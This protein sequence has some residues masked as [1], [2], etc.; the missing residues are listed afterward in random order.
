MRSPTTSVKLLIGCTTAAVG[1]SLG[2]VA[3]PA[4]TAADANALAPLYNAGAAD[5]IPSS[6]IVV[7]DATQP[8]AADAAASRARALGGSVDATFRTA[9]RGYAATLSPAALAA[10]RADAGESV[11]A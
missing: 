8:S 11:A 10:V 3:A 2:I 4:A 7:L 5:V 9:L 1:L 6:Y